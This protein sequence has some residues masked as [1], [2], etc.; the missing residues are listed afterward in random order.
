MSDIGWPSLNGS[1]KIGD[2]TVTEQCPHCG[3][4]ISMRWSVEEFGYQ[5]ICPVCG[6]AFML[7]SE[8]RSAGGKPCDYSSDTKTCML[9]STDRF[10]ELRAYTDHRLDLP[11]LSDDPKWLGC[12]E[13][14]FEA[15]GERYYCSVDAPSL[16][17]ALGRFFAQHPHITYDMIVE[18]V[19]SGASVNRRGRLS[20]L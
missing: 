2:Y 8:C 5:A 13:I 16:N 14:I 11:A 20:G 12:Y 1:P 10:S 17:N 15:D 6:G 18:H 9:G 3:N 19:E 7:C 4:E